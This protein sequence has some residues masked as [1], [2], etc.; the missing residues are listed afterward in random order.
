MSVYTS[1]VSFYSSPML[2]NYSAGPDIPCWMMS[3]CYKIPT[4]LSS[5][6]VAA[7]SSNPI[8]V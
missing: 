6:N 2:I 5:P 4:T 8:Q 3:M 7:V 1:D